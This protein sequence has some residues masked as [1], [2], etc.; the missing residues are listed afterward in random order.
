MLVFNVRQALTGPHP[1]H[2]PHRQGAVSEHAEQGGAVDLV[3]TEQ[4]AQHGDVEPG[5]RLQLQPH[6][7]PLL[8][9]GV[10]GQAGP[11]VGEAVVPGHSDG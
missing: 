10:G 1:S 9:A 5:A 2:L 7:Q 6:L 4:L 8:L 3:H 11:G